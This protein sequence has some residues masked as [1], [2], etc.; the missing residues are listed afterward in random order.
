MGVVVAST[1]LGGCAS[2][3]PTGVRGALVPT[4]IAALFDTAKN[5]T[6]LDRFAKAYVDFVTAAKTERLVV[7]RL[8]RRADKAP[9]APLPARA[10]GPGSLYALSSRGKALALVAIGKRPIS[11]GLNVLMASIDAPALGL[12]QNALYAKQRFALFDTWFRGPLAEHRW[13]SVPLALYGFVARDA[14]DAA[15][16]QVGDGPNDPVFVVPDL[17][18]HLSATAQAKRIIEPEETD[19]I[20]GHGAVRKVAKMLA[21]RHGVRA[22]EFEHA[23]L[24]LVPAGPARF[25]GVD[26]AFVAGYGHSA[27]AAAFAFVRALEGVVPARTTVV[28]L[29]GAANG[30]AHGN[31]GLAFVRHAVGQVQLALRETGDAGEPDE[32]ALRRILARSLVVVAEPSGGAL[33][34]GLVLNQVQDDGFP[35]AFQKVLG[36]FRRDRV[37]FQISHKWVKWPVLAREVTAWNVDAV[38]LSIPVSDVGA[39]IEMVSTVDLYGLF[40]AARAIVRHVE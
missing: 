30:D 13:L 5:R 23:E 25:I 27:R 37:P 9:V 32:P 10:G 3:P 4:P 28:A 29:V 39:P 2:R 24:S 16:I 6:E 40:A 22:D 31:V 17:L 26:R 18:P 34:H 33:A 8:S 38:G 19:A 20:A 21:R 7:H 12:K 14:G 1:L 36:A 11:A 35:D 15:H